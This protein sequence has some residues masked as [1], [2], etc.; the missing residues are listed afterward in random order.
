[1]R[2]ELAGLQSC[3]PSTRSEI[4]AAHDIEV[5]LC[6]V[7]PAF[8]FPWNPGLKPA[9]KVVA[10]NLLLK[11][12]A[13]KHK[14]TYVD[15]FSAMVDENMGLKADLGYDGIHP[16]EKGYS[17]MELIIEDAFTSLNKVRE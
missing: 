6:S 17:I 8:D 9:Q 2:G 4:A 1:V 15:Y 14:L 16:N 3:Q 5:I 11:E 12:Y 7:L 10:L 13:D